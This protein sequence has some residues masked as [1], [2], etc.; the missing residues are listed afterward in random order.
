MAKSLTFLRLRSRTEGLGE[1][2]GEE[3]MRERELVDGDG[4]E[5]LGLGGG[6][7]WGKIEK[8][9]GGKSLF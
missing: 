4:A 7:G 3:A 1:E 6:G 2:V 9:F 5:G 8:L